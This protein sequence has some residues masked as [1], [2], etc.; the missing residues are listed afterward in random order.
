MRI[1]SLSALLMAPAILFAQ[2]PAS[3][4]ERFNAEL[5]V[6][7]GLQKQFKAK[8]AL[9][10]AEALIPNPVPAFNKSTIQE[11]MK[12]AED[13]KGLVAIYRLCANAAV[14]SGDWEKG[15]DYFQKALDAAKESQEGIKSASAPVYEQWDKVVAEGTKYMNENAARKKELEEK[16]PKARQEQMAAVEAAQKN[17]SLKAEERKAINEKGAQLQKDE[18]ELE[19]LTANFK[20][21]Q[22]NAAKAKNVRSIL[23]ES[24]KAQEEGVKKATDSLAKLA[25]TIEKRAKEIADFNAEQLKK[26][27]K[28][29]GN[30]TWV[31]AILRNRNN[32]TDL[33]TPQAQVEFLNRLLVHDPG[34]KEAT[35]ILNDIMQG[36]D[37]FAKPVRTSGK[38]G[39]KKK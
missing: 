12:N 8:E 7:Q 17:K 16:L 2:A 10:K 14:A 15:K 19:A 33:Q 11:A 20:V 4:V 39:G 32:I 36:K 9:A 18:E 3:L 31:D 30:T 23:G 5:P 6:V 27:Q 28:V 22:D 29:V 13:F 26:R 24:V 35:R 38:K 25:E 1:R 37:P 34:N 21:H